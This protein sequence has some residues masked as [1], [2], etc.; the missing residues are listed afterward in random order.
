M[1]KTI[2]GIIM[3]LSIATVQAGFWAWED[4]G[5]FAPYQYGT[6]YEVT[7]YNISESTD[8]CVNNWMLVEYYV[9]Q[10]SNHTWSCDLDYFY[11]PN[12]CMNLPWGWGGECW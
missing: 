3:L 1:K 6:C 11:C 2:L 12:V 10:T 8:Y 9:N 4:D 5:G 7:E